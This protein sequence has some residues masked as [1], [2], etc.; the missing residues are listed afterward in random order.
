MELT[1]TDQYPYR[2]GVDIQLGDLASFS[3]LNTIYADYVDSIKASDTRDE[4]WLVT[5]TVGDGQAE[6]SPLAV[7]QRRMQGALSA[8]QV[9]LLSSN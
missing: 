5:A 7:V 6:E 1:V 8:L 3:H 4:R 9:A 2:F